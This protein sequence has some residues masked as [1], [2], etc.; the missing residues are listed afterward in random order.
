MPKR[1]RKRRERYRAE[2][3]GITWVMILGDVTYT[4]GVCNVT[5]RSIF[6]SKPRTTFSVHCTKASSP[7]SLLDQGRSRS[8]RICQGCSPGNRTPPA[9]PSTGYGTAGHQWHAGTM[10]PS[11]RTTMGDVAKHLGVSRATVSKA[12]NPDR[13]RADISEVMRR[14]V[15]EA[16]LALGFHPEGDPRW[17]GHSR[18]RIAGLVYGRVAPHLGGSYARLYEAILTELARHGWGLQFIP[19]IDQAA[20]A[21]LVRRLG[22]EAAIVV[23]P[24]TE[25]VDAC[26]AESSLPAVAL[27]LRPRLPIDAI[28]PDDR[29]AAQEL[30]RLLITHG[31]R[32]IA[33]VAPS[34]RGGWG[35]GHFSEAARRSGL[36][37][38]VAAAGGT[39]DATELVDD[40]QGLAEFTAWLRT[41]DPTAVFAYGVEVACG[42]YKAAARLGWRLP[43]DLSV[44]AGDG[45]GFA[46][47]LQPALTCMELPVTAMAEA[48]VERLLVRVA[49]E[50]GPVQERLLK[51]T[52]VERDSVSSPRRR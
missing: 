50:T 37:S 32:R 19:T 15:R 39:M 13:T 5:F 34:T 51:G 40:E 14:R 6:L 35:S 3:D 4:A 36:A 7:R 18:M 38:A 44:V 47:F 48:V 41:T 52:L 22:I 25:A 1:R 10:N 30:G 11:R 49:G 8:P 43:Q 9:S 31:H 24:E 27:N 16:A 17:S 45:P 46:R 28:L 20:G 21:E 26:L 12:L 23:Q 2:L 29:G 42:V 33:Y